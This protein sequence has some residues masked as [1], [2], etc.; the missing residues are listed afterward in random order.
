MPAATRPRGALVRPRRA[1]AGRSPLFISRLSAAPPLPS[2]RIKDEAE[3]QKICAAARGFVAV[4]FAGGSVVH[5]PACRVVAGAASPGVHDAG[6]VHWR[7]YASM[8]DAARAAAPLVLCP[9]CDPGLDD[10]TSAL[11]RS[12][13][14]LH[15]EIYRI[16]SSSGYST[17]AEHPV[18]VAPFVQDPSS[19][20]RTTAADG[21]PVDPETFTVSAAFQRAMAESQQASL[22]RQRV[23]DI[24]ATTAAGRSRELVL[25]VEVKKT[26][27]GYVDW[28]FMKYN[29]GKTGMTA[30]LISTKREGD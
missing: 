3:L 25:P 26:D 1:S 30:T 10:K 27:P 21:C 5:T 23:L 11:N 16:L 19:R 28:V 4:P 18:H 24:V 13:A 8:A 15:A 22:A 20:L 14:F 9:D 17:T 6:I 7:W 12:G 29:A 2:K